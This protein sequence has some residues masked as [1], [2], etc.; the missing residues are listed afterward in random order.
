MSVAAR[1]GCRPPPRGAGH[2]SEMRQ[3]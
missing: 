3:A 2:A 1:A